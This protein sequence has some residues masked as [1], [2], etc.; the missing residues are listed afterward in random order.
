M[1]D[2]KSYQYPW[3]Y[4]NTYQVLVDGAAYFSAMLDEIKNAKYR[5]LFEAYLFESGNT[6]D[7]FYQ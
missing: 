3:R 1:K 5:I 6:S 2:K 4:N 7:T